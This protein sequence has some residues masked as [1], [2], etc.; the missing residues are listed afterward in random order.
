M[1]RIYTYIT[2]CLAI[3]AGSCDDY[4]DT[5]NDP[6][7][8]GDTYFSA[9]LTT[10]KACYRPGETV[11]FTLNQQPASNVKVRYSH[12]G[13]A[14]GEENLLSASW[15]WT[16]PV[17]DYKGYMVDIYETTNGEEKIHHTIAVDVSSDWKKFPRYGFLSS[18]GNI[19]AAQIE[20]NIAALSRYHI[21]G[22]QFYDWMHDHQRPLAGTADDPLAS[23]PDLIGRTNYL[24]TVTGYIDA[25]H[26]KGMKTMFY[27]L[28][29][30]ALSNA[31][32]DGVKEEW[33]LFKDPDHTD[34]DNHHLDAPFRSSIYLTNPANTEWQNYLAARHNDVYKVFNFDGYHID[35]LGNRGT[36]YDYTGNAVKL[37]ESYDDFI[38][39]MKKAQPNKRLV[40]NAVS[41]YGQQKSI[42]TS[43]VDFLYT[44]IWDESKT[45]EQLAQVI[46]DNN[47]YSNHTK[48][49]VLAA[50]MNYAR[51]NNTGFI[52][53]PGVLL[54]NA[55]IFAFG[56]SHLEL[57]EH[58]LANEYFPNSNLQ[59][60]S[61][62]QRSLTHYYDFLVAYQNLL[63]DG[64]TFYTPKTR[65]A[66]GKLSLESWPASQGSIALTGKRFADKDVIHLINFTNATSMEWRDTNGTQK[67]PALITDAPITIETGKTVTKVWLASPD[68]NGGVAR[69][70]SFEQVAGE[71]TLTMPSI[72]YW[73]M[74][75]LEY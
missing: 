50:Y 42:A 12:A 32:S 3:I 53:T 31:A 71:V 54:A 18:Y 23:W 6:V 52:N 49:T 19:S 44:E 69:S 22:I 74:L 36:V 21:N 27:N 33:Y 61:E 67:E 65:S 66:D 11:Y 59:M 75:V 26:N 45:F 39:A 35:Q 17:E 20:K 14:I 15:S 8:Y 9:A 38:A 24:S 1:K 46:L 72:K 30:G 40:M 56:G 29:F 48:Q 41:Q 57:G 68:I 64:G 70:L 47:T 51:S 60:K 5:D 28:A 73:N 4:Y 37:D 25:A 63:R 10:D 55:V 7:V 13:K 16:P 58:Y 34:K 43:D 62:T 2:I